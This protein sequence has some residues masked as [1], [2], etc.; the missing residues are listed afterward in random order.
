[1]F[2]GVDLGVVENLFSILVLHLRQFL[3]TLTRSPAK[4]NTHTH[5]ITNT[6]ALASQPSKGF[7]MLKSC[8]NLL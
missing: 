7:F 1:M 3:Q 5:T 6:H 2:Q 4:E 8:G